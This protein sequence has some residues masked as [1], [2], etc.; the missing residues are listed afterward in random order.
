VNWD[1]GG[2]YWDQNNLAAMK[3]YREFDPSSQVDRWDTPIL[4]FQG[5][6][7]YRVPIGQGLEAFQAAQLKGLKSKLVYL[8]DENHWV[9]HAQNAIVW[10]REFFKW[11]E[12]TL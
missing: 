9:L 5:G 7:D 3:S 2:N 12:E 1:L 4:I 10:Q 11:L 8:P 6:K